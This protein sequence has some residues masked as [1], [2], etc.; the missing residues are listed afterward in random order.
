LPHNPG[1]HSCIYWWHLSLPHSPS[2]LSVCVPGCF[3]FF[4]FSGSNP[5]LPGPVTIL[6]KPPSFSLPFSLPEFP[7]SADAKSQH[8][9]RLHKSSIQK[10]DD[11]EEIG[12]KTQE[13]PEK[14]PENRESVKE[15]CIPVANKFA[16]KKKRKE[17]KIFTL[18]SGWRILAILRNCF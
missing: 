11:E 7:P 2:F 9:L 18:F 14:E 15:R 10:E 16:P 17:K 5:W 1:C 12:A 3:F 4:F 8:V 6:K 13:R